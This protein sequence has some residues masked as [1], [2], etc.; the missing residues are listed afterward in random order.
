MTKARELL[1]KIHG[2]VA[3]HSARKSSITN[4]MDANVNPLHVQQITG[5]KKLESLNQYC[6]ANFEQQK[7]MSLA[8]SGKDCI[9]SSTSKN[10]ST[11]KNASSTAT[12]PADIENQLL[13]PWSWKNPVQSMFHGATLS[14]CTFNINIS[15]PSSSSISLSPQKPRKR[16]RVIFED[17]QEWDWSISYW[18]L[19]WRYFQQYWTVNPW[20]GVFKNL[21]KLP[22]NFFVWIVF[23]K[24]SFFKDFNVFVKECY[25]F[26]QSNLFCFCSK[27]QRNVIVFVNRIFSFLFKDKRMFLYDAYKMTCLFSFH[28]PSFF[29]F[30]FSIWFDKNNND[31]VLFSNPRWK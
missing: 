17:S 1:P 26:C 2:K 18:H 15:A 5:H 23:K 21:F 22:D 8:I 12:I 9:Q 19:E 27:R 20:H 29:S 16:R 25:R 6:R 31:G 28:T 30:V 24:D 11:S 13:E 7:Q 4:M 14:N 3:N 10:L